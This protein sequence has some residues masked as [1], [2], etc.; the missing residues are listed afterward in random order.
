MVKITLVGCLDEKVQ[1]TTMAHLISGPKSRLHT[2]DLKKL[3]FGIGS[4]VEG[5]QLFKG[6]QKRFTFKAGFRI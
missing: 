1:D 6:M 4:H 2:C 5:L 3:K